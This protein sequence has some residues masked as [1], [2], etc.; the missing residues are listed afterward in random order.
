VLVAERVDAPA[1]PKY[2]GLERLPGQRIVAVGRRGKF[3]LLPLVPPDAAAATTCRAPAGDELIVHLGMTGV[4]RPTPPQAHLRVRLR[5]SGPEPDRLYF[6]DVRRFGRFTVV[7]AGDYRT[8]PT[9]AALGP[10][11]LAPEF[12]PRALAQALA[13]S[14]MAIKPLL[15]TQ[16]PVAGLGNIYADEALWRARIHPARPARAL[17]PSQVAAL[18]A[19]LRAVL[20]ES[21]ALQGT[22]VHDYRTVAGETGAFAARLQVYGHAGAPCPRCGRA[23]ERLTLGQRGTHVCPRCQPPPRKRRSAGR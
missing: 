18:H 14:A 1:G 19:A 23:L 13:R 10:D 2:A 21:L 6:Q 5:L 15:L 8:L 16:R 20:E 9:L 22:T 11:A 3:L 17:R 4:V 7:A 12:T